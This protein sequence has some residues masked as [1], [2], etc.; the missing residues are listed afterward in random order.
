MNREFNPT[1]TLIRTIF[2]AAAV[3]ATVTLAD[4]IEGLVDHYHAK[5][6]LANA[7]PVVVAQR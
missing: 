1:S 4:S 6:Q 7:Q 5:S 2:A 3:L